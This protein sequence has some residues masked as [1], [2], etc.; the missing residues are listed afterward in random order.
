MSQE[1]WVES[2]VR[3]ESIES[4]SLR[5]SMIADCFRILQERYPEAS[6][7]GLADKIYFYE[8]V[9]RFV[10]RLIASKGNSPQVDRQ[11][12]FFVDNFM[13]NYMREAVKK[14][15]VPIERLLQHYPIILAAKAVSELSKR[16]ENMASHRPRQL[17]QIVEGYVELF[18]ETGTLAKSHEEILRRNI[19]ELIEFYRISEDEIDEAAKTLSRKKY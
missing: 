14:E 7:F 15:T 2:V 4:G 6:H 12:R 19:A 17:Q 13:R 10:D 18:E 9:V 16:R 5:G 8:Q 1:R 3:R 11:S